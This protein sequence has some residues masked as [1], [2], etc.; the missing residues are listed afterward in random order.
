MSQGSL[1]SEYFLTDGIALSTDWPAIKAL[2]LGPIKAAV[3]ELIADFQQ[4]HKPNEPAR[5]GQELDYDNP[6]S[7]PGLTIETDGT[8]GPED[9]V[10]YA[11]GPCL[12]ERSAV[13]SSVPCP[14]S[15][16]PCRSEHVNNHNHRENGYNRGN[17]QDQSAICLDRTLFDAPTDHVK[18]PRREDCEHGSEDHHPDADRNRMMGSFHD[19]SRIQLHREFLQPQAEFGHQKSQTHHRETCAHPRQKR[20]LRGKKFPHVVGGFIGRHNSCLSCNLDSARP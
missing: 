18:M 16:A 2:D 19:R 7:S 8:V 4:R 12:F 9:A 13:A 6:G 17:R 11:A 5:V 1:F 10:A 14:L 3:G 15:N 20:T